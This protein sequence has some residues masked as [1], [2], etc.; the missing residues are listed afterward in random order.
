[1]IRKAQRFDSDISIG[2]I[3]VLSLSSGL[4]ALIGRSYRSVGRLVGWSVIKFSNFLQ[5]FLIFT[6]VSNLFCKYF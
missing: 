1:M 2:V 6:K 5:K 4:G 3:Q